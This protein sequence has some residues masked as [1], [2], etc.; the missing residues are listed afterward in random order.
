MPRITQWFK[1]LH[2]KAKQG[3]ASA[4]QFELGICYQYGKQGMHQDH[5]RGQVVP[6]KSADQ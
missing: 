4:H 5:A 2:R 1:N 3:Y 6:R